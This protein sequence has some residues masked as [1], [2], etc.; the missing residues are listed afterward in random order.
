MPT[1]TSTNFQITPIDAPLG[2]VVQQA[3]CK[4]TCCT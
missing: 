2:A 1:L 3:G 4:P